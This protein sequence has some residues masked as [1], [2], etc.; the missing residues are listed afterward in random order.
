VRK[1]PLTH[2][3]IEETDTISDLRFY[4][5]D[6]LSPKSIISKTVQFSNLIYASITPTP[7]PAPAH[8]NADQNIVT[9]VYSLSP[10]GQNPIIH[11][12]DNFALTG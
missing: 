6:Q 7:T 11:F 8:P 2:N 5:C 9:D 3:T 12:N 1:S 10:Y 4:Y